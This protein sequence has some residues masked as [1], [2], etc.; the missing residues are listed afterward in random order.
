MTLEIGGDVKNSGEIATRTLGQTAQDNCGTVNVRNSCKSKHF[1]DTRRAK[2]I[3]FW[4]LHDECL[5]G[6][7][8]VSSFGRHYYDRSSHY[9]SGTGRHDLK[10]DSLHYNSLGVII[11]I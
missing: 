4:I 3:I 5:A 2:T 9:S 10:V 1:V 11:Y 7:L 6:N 8:E